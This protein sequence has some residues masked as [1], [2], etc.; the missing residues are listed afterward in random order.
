MHGRSLT[1]HIPYSVAQW[2]S[3][4]PAGNARGVSSIPAGGPCSSAIKP[5][6]R[7]VRTACSQLLQ[8]VVDKLLTSCYQLITRLMAIVDLLQVCRNKSDIVW[9]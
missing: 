2:Q 9:T 6:S 4:A 3:S 7:C 5:L 8:Q 1:L